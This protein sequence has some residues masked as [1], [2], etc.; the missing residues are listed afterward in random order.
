MTDLDARM[1]FSSTSMT[2]SD[3]AG[4]SHQVMRPHPGIHGQTPRSDRLIHRQSPG[5]DEL[6]ISHGRRLLGIGRRSRKMMKNFVRYKKSGL[7]CLA[8]P[9]APKRFHESVMNTTRRSHKIR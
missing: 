7:L 5:I 6:Q 9:A 8:K 2:S 4:Y 3:T 1:T